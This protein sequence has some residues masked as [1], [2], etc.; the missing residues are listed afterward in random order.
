[1]NYLLNDLRAPEPGSAIFLEVIDKF[2]E[3][4]DM[5][6]ISTFFECGTGDTGDNAIYFSTFFKVI[7]VDLSEQLYNKYCNRKGVNHDVQFL[8]GDASLALK[9]YLIAHPNERLLILL[10]DHTGYTSFI[11]KELNIIDTHSLRNDHIIIVEVLWKRIL[12]HKEFF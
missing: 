4:I 9:E 7:T 8:L 1:M 3:V 6:D 10:D 11:E 5:T 12:S 2:K